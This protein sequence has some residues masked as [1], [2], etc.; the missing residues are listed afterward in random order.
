MMEYEI[1]MMMLA[2]DMEYE[3]YLEVMSALEK[4]YDEDMDLL[5]EEN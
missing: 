1:K 4:E 5:A 3:D 2:N